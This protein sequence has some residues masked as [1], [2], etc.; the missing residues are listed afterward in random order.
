MH[1]V[2]GFKMKLSVIIPCFNE[3]NTIEEVIEKVRAV[4]IGMSKEIIVV[5]DGSTDGT[6]DILKKMEDANPLATEIHHHSIINLG[7]GAAVRI[8]LKHAT[9]DIVLIQDA[10]LELDPAEYPRLLAPILSGD[11][12]VVFG[13]RNFWKGSRLIT[14]VANIFLSQLTSL[15]F[16]NHVSDMETAYKVMRRSVVEPIRLRAVG[17]ELEPELT[18]K[19]LRLGHQ[20]FEVPL[21]YYNPRTEAEGKKIGW[22][23]GF[24]A[25]FFLFKYRMQKTEEFLEKPMLRV[26]P[27][28]NPK[29]E[30]TSAN[31]AVEAAG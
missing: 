2:N 28:A 9:G 1:P 5:D 6:A 27:P 13:T 3:A 22:T 19:L 23:D 11:T 16:G 18:A 14:K 10:D 30:E 7:K 24:K 12:D 4:D 8:G 25:I 26:L 20:I 21:Q 15:L 29:Q 17:F 31:K